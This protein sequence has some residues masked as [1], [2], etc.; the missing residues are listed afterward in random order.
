M[1]SWN[2]LPGDRERLGLR[3]RGHGHDE[4]RQVATVR[5]VRV[6]QHQAQ[7]RG[8]GGEEEE[9][10]AVAPHLRPSHPAVLHQQR[11]GPVA[12]VGP[13]GHQERVGRG[14]RT[15]QL[16][17]FR[18][19]VP[20]ADAMT[21]ALMTRSSDPNWLQL[22]DDPRITRIG[23]VL[24]GTS[25]DEIPQLWNVLVGHMSLVGPRPLSVRDDARVNGWARGR[26]DITPGLTGLWQVSGRKSVSFEEM[27]KL[28]YLYVN[29]WSVWGDVKLLLLTLPAVIAGR[30]AR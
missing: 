27:V 18:T 11:L 6:A 5:A 22:E 3:G 23:R 9:Q 19:M 13:L 7:Q 8:R 12:G 17:K 15:F 10:R 25:L 16:L 2:R 1:V 26:L 4:G 30:G 21:E 29:N 24:R 28:D 20:D 14:G